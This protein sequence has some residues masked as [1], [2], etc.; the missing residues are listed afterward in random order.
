MIVFGTTKDGQDVHKITISAGNL[1]VNLLTWGAAVQDVRLAG[2]DR[3]LT[4]GSDHLADYEGD[5]RH[6]GALIGPVANR[7]STARVKLDGM[8][9]E[10]ERNQDGRIHLHSGAQA[11]HLRVWDIV[12]VTEN[13]ATLSL[14]LPD[15]MCGLPGNR[16]VTATFSVTT[17]AT[18]TLQINATTDST[19]L[20]NFANHSYWNLDG[21]PNYEGHRLRIAADRYLPTTVDDCPTG[22]IVD[23]AGTQMDLRTAR[24]VTIN[25]PALDHNFCL[26]DS[27]QPLRDVLVLSGQSGVQMTMATTEPG[28]QVFDARNAPR[29]GKALY[30]GLAF[31]AQGWPDA[32]NHTDF[33]SIKVTPDAPYHQTTNWQFKA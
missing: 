7:I 28:L 29:P 22:E 4:L 12:H 10:L 5:M 16:T 31:E 20:M 32:P 3:S 26:S 23:V 33:P 21:S 15:G 24:V 18:L 1:T 6:Y 27:H 8:M 17:D 2:I 13:T 14:N 30:E 11:T 25:A 19:T 9:H